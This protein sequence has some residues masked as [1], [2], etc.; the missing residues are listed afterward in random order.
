MYVCVL[1]LVM[2]VYKRRRERRVILNALLLSKLIRKG[3]LRKYTAN[4]M[5]PLCFVLLLFLYFKAVCTV[6][7]MF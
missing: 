6:R 2:K 3:I 7:L 1:G 5:V 4:S